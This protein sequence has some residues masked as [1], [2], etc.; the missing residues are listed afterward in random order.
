MN[1]IRKFFKF[2]KK[3][4]QLLLLAILAFAF[5]TRVYRLHLPEK[6]I[7][8]E[9]YHA[10]TA[11]LI[12]R[13]DPR[14]FEWWNP[15]P[16]PST[17]VDWLHPPVA[18]YTQAASMLVFGETSFGW[19]FSSALFGVGV[20]YLTYL[21]GKKVFN[22]EAVGLLAAWLASLDGL[23]LVQ[24][25][26]AMN[27]IH[28]T[29][30]ILLTLILYWRHRQ[31]GKTWEWLPGTGLSLLKVGLTAGLAMATKWSGVYV[32]VLVLGFESWDLLGYVWKL[33]QG[34]VSNSTSSKVNRS[35]QFKQNLINITRTKIAL[36]LSLIILP[37]T[38]Y[39]A[40]YTTM[41][42]QGKTLICTQQKQIQTEC[43]F[44]RIQL[45]KYTLWEGY[46]S[47]FVSLHRQIWWYQTH[48]DATHSFQSRPWQWFLN[49]RPV[50]IDVDY[51]ENTIANIY[52][53][54]NPV[55]F[56]AGAVSV[57]ISGGYILWTSIL[58]FSHSIV[59]AQ[60]RKLSKSSKKSTQQQEF[61][62]LL[63]ISPTFH[64][65]FYLLIS[66]LI[67]WTPWFASP[68][69]MF[70]YHYTPAVPTMSI[71]LGFGLWKLWGWKS[72]AANKS[73]NSHHTQIF[74]FIDQV[75]VGRVFVTIT[76]LATLVAFITWYPNW[77]G[78]AVPKDFADAVYFGVK[79]WK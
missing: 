31:L 61:N 4:P 65:L 7:F 58:W 68:R 26:I 47:H 78:I 75:K 62:K 52:A 14:A 55:L 41:F 63:K 76:V 34:I 18:K 9:V 39:I 11:K 3:N 57:V 74:D 1:H 79:G 25:R 21:L 22:H 35:R 40:S 60:L 36:F 30:F 66:Y 32:L 64:K 16:E 48:L 19:R 10:V 13:N 73:S 23:L 49:L 20:I 17:A 54:G 71:L 67:V 42:I 53:F 33:W 46:T 12:A 69:I 28:V 50:W 72:S 5:A 8:D 2:W 15:A 44:E 56:W 27:D 51:G 37:I 45:G 59:A 70:F 6:Y 24:S 38:I 43:Y 77:T 29:F